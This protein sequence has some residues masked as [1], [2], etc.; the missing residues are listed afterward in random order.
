MKG[1]TTLD[2]NVL[3]LSLIIFFFLTSTATSQINITNQ[4]FDSSAI[5]TWNYTTILNTGTI[6]TSTSSSASAPNSLRL[7]G[8]NNIGTGPSNNDP[9]ILFSNQ[10]LA[11]FTDVQLSIAFSS[12]GSP[13][14]YDNLYLDLSYDNGITFITSIKL[15][16]GKN[17]TS[18]NLPFTHAAS[19]GNTVGSTYTID[20]PNINTQIRVRVRFNES[21]DQA[22]STDY[23]YIDNIKLTGT[24][25]FFD[26][27]GDSIF[28]NTDI[29]DDNDGIKDNI[30]EA[31]CENSNG[32]KVNY[33]FLNETFGT[34]T[35]TTINTTY[36][37][38]TTYCYEDGIAGVNTTACPGQSSWILDDGEYCVTNK[39]TGTVASDP[40]NIHG[41]LA[42]YNGEDHTS[43]DTNGRMAVFNASFAPGTF[44]ETTITGVLSNIPITY[45]FWVLNIM[46]QSTFPNSILPNVTVEFI[47]ASNNIISTFNTGDIGRC[48]DS[49]TDNTCAQGVWKKF[50]TSVNLGSINVFTV[51]FRNNAPGGG[52]NDL[53][54]DDILITQPLCDL[55][56][57]GVADLFDLDSDNDGIP[58]VVE[59]GLG[60]LSNA[61]GKIDVA[62]VDANGNGLH[63]AAEGMTI[64][65]DNDGDGIPNY[66]DLDS[67]ND[68]I[69]DVDES[70]TGNILAGFG[71]DNGDGDINGDGVGDGPETE[72]IRD[73][74][75][76]GDGI[77][78]K[79][80]DGIL[81]IYDYGIGAYGNLNQGTAIAPF[82]NY[83]LD[84]DGDNLPNYIDVKSNG[85]T[86]DI[87][88]TLYASLD[89][90]NDGKIDGTTDI[91]KDGILDAFDTNTAF[92]GSPRNLE[93]K[94]FIEFDGK[95]DYGQDISVINGWPNATI[96]A[97]INLN[98]FYTAEGIIVGQDKLQLKVNGSRELQAV[99]NGTTITAPIP[100]TAAQWIHTA[101]VYDSS[102]SLLKLYINGTMVKNTAISGNLLADTSP[103]TIGKNPSASDK[104]FRGSID[105]IRVFDKALTDAQLQKMVYQEIQDNSGQIRGA[106]IPKDITALPWTNLKRYYKMDNFKNNIIDDH[107]TATIDVTTGAKIYNV[108]NIK[109]QQAPMPFVTQQTGSIASSVNST[110]NQIRGQDAV[111]NNCSIIIVNHNITSAT[112]LTNLGL[113]INSSKNVVISNDS[114]LQ[115]DWYLKL[116]GKID[117][118]GRSQLVQTADSDLEPTSSGSLE[119]DQQGTKNIF[120]YNYWSS[121]VGPINAGSNNNNYTVGAVFKDGTDAAN[122]TSI[123]WIGGYNGT[124]G[125]PIS[126]ARYWIYKFQNVSNAYANWTQILN[127]GTLAPS[128]G[129]TLKGS[130]TAAANQNYT[131][132]GKPF[133]GTITNP[134]AA[135]NLNLSGNPYASAIDANAF[136]NDNASSTNGTLYFWEH[137]TTNNTHNLAGYQGGY[138]TRNLT[139][140]TV[141]VSPALISGL[142]SST[143]IPGRFI[144]VGQGF[145]I[146]GNTTG[147]NIVFK[148][149]QRRFIKEANMNSNVMFRNS[150]SILTDVENNDDD[151]YAEDLFLKIR[152]GY[153]SQN[154]YHRQVLLGF[155]NENATSGLDYGYDGILFDE[156]TNDMAFLHGTKKLMIQGDGYFNT[157]N[158]YP[159]V[160]KSNVAGT[161]KFMIDGL[162]NFDSEQAIYIYD[163]DTNTYHDIRNEMFEVAIPVGEN[164]S[165]FSLRF[166]QET[167]SMNENAITEINITHVQNGNLLTINNESLDITVKKIDLFNIIGQ[168]IVNWDVENEE[169]QKIQIPIQNLSS[170]TY[171]AKIQTSNGFISKKIIVK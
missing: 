132:I 87:S 34:G 143:R 31:N 99:A 21:D 114:K 131:F 113:F 9:Y 91:D 17:D 3:F 125:T 70:C 137:Y 41:D 50:T 48:S 115:N 85:T 122:P 38:T 95:N 158:V 153:T 164:S 165:R 100:L 58:D 54:L 33:K 51:R 14:D 30:E 79:F 138:A 142:G 148:N 92:Y 157:N 82:L 160:V 59:V 93:R 110:V 5:D 149:S 97:W 60:N 94:L 152:L 62:W 130:G 86:F 105:E 76:N 135:N 69:F 139:G 106:I 141:P 80:G 103:F 71:F 23:Y 77:N 36:D 170:G 159:V 116:D 128:Q 102:N 107:T 101:V 52:G 13:D 123:N 83:L 156:Q 22:N 74:D 8:S 108:K 66:I 119:R 129:F 145:F 162:E 35:R 25:T 16:D 75:T 140:G 57:D 146:G 61:K 11:N 4:G 49:I 64:L 73:K 150:V 136:I 19:A 88:T 46:A 12:F 63:D 161:V 47:D 65:L 127:T 84:L 45:S 90:N 53:A 118:Q 2:K 26:S 37:A 98:N 144:P 32:H 72:T 28:D 42:W 43:G 40:E 112:N 78:E 20:I 18:D 171:I 67:D 24:Q 111:D 29:D 44:Y 126:L 104:F 133:N 10:S 154:N 109:V 120:N 81:D 163:N 151:S 39:I 147:G 27:D 15:I 68:S 56:N 96:M 7:G 124:P 168:F 169:Q 134:I 89:S 166:T 167:L 1:K 155:M 117:L 6:A 121:P 55:D